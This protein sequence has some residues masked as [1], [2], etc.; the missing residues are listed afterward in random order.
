[1]VN[2]G[3]RRTVIEEQNNER[4]SRNSKDD[5]CGCAQR[6][7]VGRPQRQTHERLFLV[8]EEIPC[9]P[10][11]HSIRTAL[12]NY[13]FKALPHLYTHL[14]LWTSVRSQE[15]PDSFHLKNRWCCLCSAS[16]DGVQ[17][18]FQPQSTHGLNLP[19]QMGFHHKSPNVTSLGRSTL[20]GL[21]YPT[22]RR[23]Q[24]WKRRPM[25]AF[26]NMYSIYK[27]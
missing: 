18:F 9:D 8:A 20:P 10:P 4:L 24:R 21:P 14:R 1:M 6:L 2:E 25:A 5:G 16:V 27:E 15:R 13:P 11:L 7:D 23:C 12:P 22:S 26:V 3:Q 19:R 17:G